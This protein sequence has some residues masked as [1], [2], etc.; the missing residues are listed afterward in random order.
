MIFEILVAVSMKDMGCCAL[1]SGTD[2][3]KF[4]LR[5]RA[6]L[7]FKP[8]EVYGEEVGVRFFRNA[9]KPVPEYM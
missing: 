2:L 5:K 3:P 8:Q 4:L 1:Y 6:S 7:I 9:G